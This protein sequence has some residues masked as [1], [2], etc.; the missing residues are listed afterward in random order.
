MI[1]AVFLHACV[2]S[3]FRIAGAASSISLLVGGC[4]SHGLLIYIYKILINL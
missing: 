1:S 2:P 4:V 3:A